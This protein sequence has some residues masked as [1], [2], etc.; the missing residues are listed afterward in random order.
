MARMTM[1]RRSFLGVAGVGLGSLAWSDSSKG[2]AQPPAL[3][4][5]MESLYAKFL[6]PDRKYSIRPFWFW[7]GDLT[8][9]ELARQIQQMVDH[10]VYGAYAHNRDGLQVPYLSEAWWK[11]LG[12]ALQAAKAAG[13][14]LCMVDEFEWP[15]GEAR[16]YQ[17]P[18][19]NKSRVLEGNPEFRLRR[20]RP[21]ETVSKGPKRL[22]LPLTETTVAVVAAKR[23]GPDRLD[24][25]SLQ[26]LRWENGQK[27]T[28]WDVPEGDWLITTYELEPTVGN[29]G[30]ID[31]MNPE[32]TAKFINIYYDEFYRRYG[33]Y[34]GN[35]MPATFADHEGDYGGKLP[36]TPRLFETF[37]RK[38]GYDLI[39]NLPGLLYDIGPRTEKVRC[40]LL[41]T[42]S[43]LYSDSFFK[44]VG[45][46]CRQHN[47]QYS[48]H[49]WEESL[50]WGAAWQGDYF[51]IM[52]SLTTP[53]CDTLVEWA[54]QSVW[55]KEA[56]SIAAFEGQ[57]LVCE[58]QGVQGGDSYL[59]PERMRRVSNC[60]GA[61]D[62]G[63]F[64]PHA[65]N[66]D[67]ARTNFPPDWFRGQPF[68]PWFRAYA[69]QMRRIS[70]INRESQH[71]ADLLVLYPQVSI[72]GQ[73]STTFRSDAFMYLLENSNW[74]DDAVDTS[75][76]YADLKLRL[77]GARFDFMVADDHYLA[78]SKVEEG[79]LRI[80]NSDFKI[81]ILPPMST[82]RLS[83]AQ[84]IRSFY[85]A[86]GTVIALQ[87]L[88]YTSVEA[89]RDDAELKAIWEEVFDTRPSSQPYRMRKGASGGASYFVSGSVTDLL[90]VIREVADP[91]IDLIEGPSD[92][93]YA[94]HKRNNG[95]DL[96]WLVN[97][98]S[99]PHT[100]LLQLKAKGRPEKWDAPTGQRTPLFYE[101][102][103]EKT[104]V[105]LSLGP[106]DASYVVFEPSGLSQPLA[107]SSTNLDEF[108]VLHADKS[109]VTVHGRG[110]VRGEPL[111]LELQEGG[112]RYRGE[113]HPG[114]AAPL[115]IKG[116]W[117]LTVESSQI[118]LPYAQVREDPADRGVRE[119]WY[120]RTEDKA[121]W[122][123]L[124]LSP[125]MRSI[126]QWNVMGPFP[127]PGDLGLESVY[128]PENDKPVAYA[129]NYD[130]DEGQQ[131]SWHEVDSAAD[132]VG[133]PPGFGTVELLDGP[134]GPSSFIVD[135]GRVLRMSTAHG[136]IYLQTNVYIPQGEEATMV[137][138]APH[139]T[140]VYVNN[141]KAYSRWLRPLYLDF[142]DGFATR[143]PVKL[144]S[145]WNSILIKF[146]HNP[147][148]PKATQFTC[149]IER[150]N[151]AAIEGLVC[152]SKIT[153]DPQLTGP[154]YRWVRFQIPPVARALHVPPLRDSW[155]A[156]VDTREVPAS[157]EIALPRGSRAV[158]L[159]VSAKELL[160]APFA[161]ST[162][163]APMPLGTWKVPG[164]EHFSGIM[165]YEKT[166]EVPAS[167]L[168]ERV[169]LD[170]G[171]VGVC[172]EAWV[173]GKAV[174]S[175]PWSPYVFDVTE[176]LH[177][178]ENQFKV[179]V[180]NTEA[181][182]RAVGPSLPILGNIDMDGWQGPARLVPFIERDII[183]SVL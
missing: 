31:L 183:C 9:E 146:L 130:G 131:L 137:L 124:W 181:N 100:W 63:E 22:S 129:K 125:L 64:V 116:D 152:S 24:G 104:V 102:Q 132:S 49:V 158:T 85:Q 120:A 117:N 89:G 170:C 37:R 154:G 105:R 149:R 77:T 78:L 38:A 97:N 29:D 70:F 61:W 156:F 175:R 164:L 25:N 166:V 57:H 43:E 165:A 126:R 179:R 59:S 171:D 11:V 54:R 122:N 144:N 142:T 88:P 35:A 32:A 76:Q 15:S 94:L 3:T 150:T 160:D 123:P 1:T 138:V 140:A 46:W 17:L 182:A 13:F 45:D 5:A 103:G 18:G 136:T 153:D 86:G 101:T 82:T 110:V 14:S 167:L 178:G 71:L 39:P 121:S 93:L 147:Q 60:L 108:H 169:L 92:D 26:A 141:E 40:D 7:N 127:N 36:W 172:A 87:R 8:G 75:Q 55:L 161:F 180:A 30:T 42:V 176:L 115:E 145:G 12:E 163:S 65:F 118:P 48:G 10:G 157:P 67:L 111:F 44:Q 52:R 91:Y 81:L 50:F 51:R 79:R 114:K 16:D 56:A 107:L 66:Y 23:L 155:R 133:P 69:D 21:I 109:K 143:I 6:D 177:A 27:E 68:L 135:Y 159:R 4:G 73:A 98:S 83:T 119:R 173:N 148:N 2:S 99:E 168:T 20:M 151:G 33:Q 84:Q 134:Y 95:I 106:W 28:S 80:A 113:Y 41:D 19:I 128:G 72:W 74:S 112:S 90:E 47:I 139:P 174:G 53:G 58:N 34:F 96:Y 62:I 162:I